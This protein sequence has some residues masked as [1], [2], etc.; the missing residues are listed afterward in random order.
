MQLV[1]TEHVTLYSL[2]ALTA[3]TRLQK[4]KGEQYMIS[5]KSHLVHRTMDSDTLCSTR[6]FLL[7]LN[8]PKL[9]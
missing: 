8:Y 4:K 5:G 9:E 3:E 7:V 1:V 2:Y 6:F